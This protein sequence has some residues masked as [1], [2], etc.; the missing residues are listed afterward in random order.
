MQKNSFRRIPNKVLIYEESDILSQSNFQ[1]QNTSTLKEE[2]KIKTLHSYKYSNSFFLKKLKLQNTTTNTSKYYFK[3]H[4]L[5]KN[6]LKKYIISNKYS[7]GWL[8]ISNI[9]NKNKSHFYSLYKDQ[10][11]YNNN[12]TEYIK[13]Y[14]LYKDSVKIIRKKELYFRHLI[15]FYERPI[16][17]NF[18]L[19]KI[20][21]KIVL[22]KIE[23]YR[24]EK[25]PEQIHNQNNLQNNDKTNSN[26]NTNNLKED[27]DN[28]IFKTD[29]IE[30]IENYSTTM[31]Q[32][33][34]LEQ[35]CNNQANPSEN[36]NK[37]TFHNKTK[38]QSSASVSQSEIEYVGGY[39]N[40][41]NNG[42]HNDNNVISIDNSLIL[43]MKNLTM[44]SDKINECLSINNFSNVN[45][46][47]KSPLK[48]NLNNY[49]DIIK[50]KK[51]IAK[52]AKTKEKKAKIEH[53]L[54]PDQEILMSVNNKNKKLIANNNKINSNNK[55]LVIEQ[56][57][58]QP[59]PI[60]NKISKTINVNSNN[61]K[62][63]FNK[64]KKVRGKSISTNLKGKILLENLTTVFISNQSKKTSFINVIP[65]SF[66]NLVTPLRTNI[67]GNSNNQNNYFSSFIYKCKK[68]TLNLKNESCNI[69]SKQT[70]QTIINNP[71][72]TKHRHSKKLSEIYPYKSNKF[73]VGSLL[74]NT[75]TNKQLSNEGTIEENYIFHEQILNNNANYNKI[76]NDSKSKSKSK[77]V[78]KKN[79]KYKKIDNK[80]TM[81]N[82]C[83]RKMITQNLFNDYSNYLI[84]YDTGL[85][86]KI[87]QKIIAKNININKNTNT[88]SSLGQNRKIFQ[89]CIKQI[90]SNK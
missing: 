23:I 12:K 31:T 48:A 61:Q 18:N 2:S 78:L 80:K 40:A 46:I 13:E 9:L 44:S 50:K 20:S 29:V 6:I 88:N 33:S 70:M 84:N 14:Y 28:I 36:S 21:R 63:I 74:T 69:M 3:C 19:N 26:N 86:K 10:L 25:Y 8:N 1:L 90:K 71:N 62:K 43:I 68:G 53:I 37:N 42:I 51:L 56:I 76:I 75:M 41:N 15:M 45:N 11:I 5:C 32:G 58:Q 55:F 54:K 72:T 85:K 73:N 87:R 24:K 34:N 22:E 59:Q 17:N 77:S 7:L 79:I 47:K 35:I 60:F 57:S 52:K 49:Q 83:H 66:N 82:K 4:I 30:T 38:E 64:N 39:S 65:P 89:P 16:Y 27:D 67:I 81:L